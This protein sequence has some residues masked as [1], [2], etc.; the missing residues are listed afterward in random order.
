ML[1]GKLIVFWRSSFKVIFRTK[2][3]IT[4]LLTTMQIKNRYFLLYLH[5]TENIE[6]FLLLWCY[7]ESRGCDDFEAL[8]AEPLRLGW[9]FFF[10]V[11][12]YFKES[13]IFSSKL[14]IRFFSII[15]SS[16]TGE[17]W[18]FSRLFVCIFKFDGKFPFFSKSKDVPLF[19]FADYRTVYE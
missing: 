6:M 8:H 11:F 16:K 17:S 15:Y 1:I 19:K 7:C 2:T 10:I 13:F 4:S 3:H 12:I 5:I 9:Y 18:L 14:W